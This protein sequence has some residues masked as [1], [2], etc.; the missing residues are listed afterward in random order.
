MPFPTITE[1]GANRM[2]GTFTDVYVRPANEKYQTLGGIMEA[3]FSITDYATNDSRKR[4]KVHGAS[5]FEA[6]FKMKQASTTE[7]EL[8]DSLQNGGN[9]FLFRCPDAAAI[10]S[11]SAATA[12]WVLVTSSQVD[13]KAMGDYSG[14]AS[15]NAFIQ[16][17]IK[18]T[19]MNSVKDAVV[20]ATIIDTDFE[21]TGDSG[22]FH[23]IGTYTAAKDGGLPKNAN[24]KPC[25][26]VSVTLAYTGGAAQTLTMFSSV[27]LTFDFT[28]K[29][30]GLGRQCVSSVDFLLEYDFTPT[31]A[32]TAL[33]LDSMVVDDVDVVATTLA[34]PVFTFSNQVGIDTNYNAP[35]DISAT[36]V[37]H[38]KHTGT[39]AKTVFDN[40]VS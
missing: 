31:D 18:G 30:D 20:K 19:V 6:S 4:N 13:A 8:L 14:D 22:T 5:L 29:P 21:A 12:G 24:M 35:A 1:S 23:A 9:S 11:G 33:V 37:I 28:G 38:F 10:P 3:S 40:I 25:G 15:A 34:G 39:V 17:T 26:L 32:P 16:V 2:P 27:K 7:L 36:R